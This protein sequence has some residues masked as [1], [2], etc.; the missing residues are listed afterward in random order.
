MVWPLVVYFVA[1]ERGGG[2]S[3]LYAAVGEVPKKKKTSRLP[4]IIWERRRVSRIESS[5][6]VVGLGTGR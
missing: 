5:F 3:G 2:A 6:A 4:P 1:P